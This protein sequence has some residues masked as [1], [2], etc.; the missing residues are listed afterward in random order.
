MSVGGPSSHHRATHLIIGLFIALALLAPGPDGANECVSRDHCARPRNDRCHLA[1]WRHLILV[2]LYHSAVNDRGSAG[3]RFDP[4]VPNVARVYDYMLGGK[5]NFAADRELAQQF[6]TNWPT[7]AWSARQQRAF[8]VRAVRYCAEQGISQ[9]LDVGSGLPTMD[10]VHQVAQRIIPE[11]AVVYVDNDQV[12]HAHANALLATTPGVAAILGDARQPRN[13]LAE[14]E[15]RGLLDFS[16]PVA[17]LMTGILHFL[18][19]AEDP[20]GIIR[21]FRDAMAP[22]SYLILTHGTMDSNPAEGKRAATVWGEAAHL[23][24]RSR[25]EFAAFFAGL[26]LVDPGIVLTVQWRPEEAVRDPELAGI[27]AAVGRK[28]FPQP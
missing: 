12:A 25:D 3:V 22:G 27:Y 21:M 8:V 28:P 19:S 1:G 4:T 24:N 9:Y 5:D 17:V 6:L 15:S 14:V 18:S 23:A 20:A 16:A 7:S 2:L 10:N 26:K 11:S 13:I